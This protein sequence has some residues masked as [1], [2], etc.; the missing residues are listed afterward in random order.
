M[1]KDVGSLL[2][3]T[4]FN[5][6]RLEFLQN[7]FLGLVDMEQNRIIKIFTVVTIVFYAPNTDCQHI[8]H[9]LSFYA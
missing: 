6:E 7:T 9:E 8:W 4:S 3:H 1:I 5:F 2:D